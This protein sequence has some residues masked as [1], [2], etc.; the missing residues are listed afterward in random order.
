VVQDIQ[1]GD[2]EHGE[3][4]TEGVPVLLYGFAEDPVII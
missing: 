1:L 4:C 3:Q 2:G